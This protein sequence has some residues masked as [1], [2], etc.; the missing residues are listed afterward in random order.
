MLSAGSCLGFLVTYGY[1]SQLQSWNNED[2]ILA[3][4]GKSNYCKKECKQGPVPSSIPPS[5]KKK[6]NFHACFTF[7]HYLK[8]I[9]I[10]FA[11]FS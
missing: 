6:R 1:I 4:N 10:Y 11:T 8:N 7:T 9:N 3:G 2:D 5:P